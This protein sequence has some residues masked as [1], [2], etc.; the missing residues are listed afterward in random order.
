LANFAGELR[1]ALDAV[2]REGVVVGLD[3]DWRG[4]VVLLLMVSTAEDRVAWGE[5]MLAPRD[6][7]TRRTDRQQDLII[8][9]KD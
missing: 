7:T 3:T 6:H 4:A 2:R 8:P 5:S 9:V 1:R